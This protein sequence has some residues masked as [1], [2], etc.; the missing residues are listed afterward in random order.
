MQHAPK[1]FI[2]I[3]AIVLL[4]IFSI[5]VIGTSLGPNNGGTFTNIPL[6]L[7]GGGGYDW[8]NLYNA[9]YSDDIYASTPTIPINI[10]PNN[11]NYLQA[12]NFGFSIPAGATIDG[13]Q[14]DVERHFTKTLTAGC[15]DA[16]VRIVQDGT[17]AGTDLVTDPPTTWSLNTDAYTTYGGA[18]ELWGLTWTVDQINSANFGF[19]IA[20]IGFGLGGTYTAYVDH[21]R[22]TVY[23]TEAATSNPC[24]CTNYSEWS[25]NSTNCG[26]TNIVCNL[27][28]HNL[29]INN[30]SNVTFNG[31]VVYNI[32]NITKS[33]KVTFIK[34]NGARVIT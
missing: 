24:I 16:S 22:I 31:T 19:S 12:T 15:Q 10:D 1:I 18:T 34:K 17:E 30:C 25:M 29:I 5:K 26:V 27:G 3:I 6:D 32:G 11:A 23:Y 2:W 9:Q 4:V 28:G 21:I 13:I 8:A 20:T 7:G 33:G 14:V